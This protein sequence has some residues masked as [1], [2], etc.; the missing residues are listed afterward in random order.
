MRFSEPIK[1]NVE[2]GYLDN[3]CYDFENGDLPIDDL[4]KDLSL[5]NGLTWKEQSKI[6]YWYNQSLKDGAESV[7]H[8]KLCYTVAEI[9]KKY[10]PNAKWCNS[11]VT[12]AHK[13]Y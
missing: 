4:N 5:F 8:L 6:R 3:I 2:C 7:A 9:I 13:F 11:F 12:T 10:L 1:N